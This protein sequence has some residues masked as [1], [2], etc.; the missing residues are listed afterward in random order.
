MNRCS[1][2]YH[3]IVTLKDVASYNF[4]ILGKN[5]FSFCLIFLPQNRA[6]NWFQASCNIY[7]KKHLFSLLSL[8]QPLEIMNIQKWKWFVQFPQRLLLGLLLQGPPNL[9]EQ[10]WF[11]IFRECSFVKWFSI[12]KGL[13]ML[14][15][16][17]AE[18]SELLFWFGKKWK[19]ENILWE[20]LWI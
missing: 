16:R 13:F 11:N 5:V 8:H 2:V 7:Q 3:D 17:P 10:R 6:C 18:T 15:G 4:H 1:V 14:K 9:N 20:F 12:D 19:Q